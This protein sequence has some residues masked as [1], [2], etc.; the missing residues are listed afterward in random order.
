MLRTLSHL[1]LGN[2]SQFGALQDPGQAVIVLDA[3]LRMTQTGVADTAIFDTVGEAIVETVTNPPDEHS[4]LRVGLRLAGGRPADE[5]ASSCEST[6]LALPPSEVLPERWREAIADHRPSGECPL[7]RSIIA[8]LGDLDASASPSRLVVVTAGGDDCGGTRE[9]VEQALAGGQLVVDLRVVGIL[10]PPEAATLFEAIPLRNVVNPDELD[11]ILR[12]ALF[13]GLRAEEPEIS[14][15]PTASVESSEQVLA[16]EP[17]EVMWVG[18]DAAEDFISLALPEDPNDT[19]VAWARTDSGNPIVLTA[20][21]QPGAYEIRY[22][23]GSGAEALARS[24]VEV[25]A[26]AIELHAPPTVVPEQRFEVRWTGSTAPGD[27]VAFSRPDA[28]SHRMLDWASTA[29]GGPVTLAA[30][31][32]TG[33]Y[34]VRFIRK[35]GL[36]IL[37][38]VP[39]EVAQ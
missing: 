32:R 8:A 18:P 5:D 11:A 20:P 10:M 16:G 37:A 23:S 27:F 14:E 6:A 38:R 17:L 15:T 21:L 2:A 3:S 12:W 39:V 19:Y 35:S 34:E 25:L 33:V 13:E 29:A 28:P 22:V 36:E 1:F 31:T 7:I 30:P 26:A 24:P 9:Q 4:D